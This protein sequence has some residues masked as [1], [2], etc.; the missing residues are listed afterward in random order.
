MQTTETIHCAICDADD[1]RVVFRKRAASGADYTVVQ[2]RHCG[3][4]YVN[5]RLSQETIL[6]TYRDPSYFQRRSDQFTGYSDYT[7][8]R[9]LHELFFREQLAKLEQRV[10]KGRILD[11]GC[12]F[13]YLLHE[14]RQ[15]GWKPE[16]IELS[17]RAVAYARDEL[18]LKIHSAPLRENQFPAATFNAVIMNDVIEHYGHPA[19]EVREVY[20]IL[21]PGGAY[22]LHTPNFASWWRLLMRRQWVHLK[23]EEHLYYFAPATISRLLRHYGFEVVYARSCGKVTNFNYIIGVLKKYSPAVAAIAQHTVGKLPWA[24]TPFHF[25][26]GG[27]EILAIKR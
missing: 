8:D 25:R 7:A 1:T 15:R 19:Q 2:C 22:L 14:A 13:G 20:R 23:P 5:P 12:A 9:E 11:I 4:V 17:G 3:L 16:G 24:T 27:M 10:P 6:G 21:A 26:G 18:K